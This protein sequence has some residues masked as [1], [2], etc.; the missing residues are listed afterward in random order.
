MINLKD[1]I[2][3]VEVNEWVLQTLKTSCR[4]R[5]GVMF[6]FH[7]TPHVNEMYSPV[8]CLEW[9]KYLFASIG[10]TYV[11]IEQLGFDEMAESWVNHDYK[12]MV[13]RH[14]YWSHKKA[15]LFMNILK[16]F[17]ESEEIPFDRIWVEK[18]Y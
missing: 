17:C 1:F 4:D 15:I 14:K 9:I 12:T 3:F 5:L 6:R 8:R 7:L 13:I 16:A 2:T 11:H 18:N 10:Y